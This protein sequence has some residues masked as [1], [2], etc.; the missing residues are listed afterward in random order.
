MGPDPPYDVA[1]GSGGTAG[2][3]GL[4]DREVDLHPDMVPGLPPI[5]GDVYAS[6]RG[7]TTCPESDLCVG[8][9]IAQDQEVVVRSGVS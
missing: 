3:S 1:E 7:V 6:N 2:T 5:D 9:C 4:R 8:C